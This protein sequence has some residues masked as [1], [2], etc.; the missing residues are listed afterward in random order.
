MGRSK[1]HTFMF[2]S[3]DTVSYFGEYLLKNTIFCTKSYFEDEIR[4]YL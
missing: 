2:Y 3:E 1:T 4:K